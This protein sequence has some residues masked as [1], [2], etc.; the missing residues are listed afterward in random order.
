MSSD[1]FAMWNL[2]PHSMQPSVAVSQDPSMFAIA[3]RVGS[4][5]VVSITSL[6]AVA[7]LQHGSLADISSSLAVDEY[8]GL[9]LVVPSVIG[10]G[11]LHSL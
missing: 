8:S 3:S 1:C 4:R 7:R 2:L 6:G 10:L 11:K 5:E 9:C